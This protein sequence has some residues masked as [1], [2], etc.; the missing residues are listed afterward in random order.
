MNKVDDYVKSFDGVK[1]EWLTSLVSYMRE[2][3]P[4]IL[5]T[6]DH[7]KPT[8]QWDSVYIAFAAQK[9]YFS[10]YTDDLT[11]L[12]CCLLRDLEGVYYEDYQ[13]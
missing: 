1:N 10:F 5:E 13:R 12:N 8:Y 2:A 7:K 6:L 11:E 9:N 3:Y 4:D